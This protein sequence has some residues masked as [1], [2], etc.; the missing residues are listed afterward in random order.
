MLTK[1][2]LLLFIFSNLI[3]NYDLIH[4]TSFEKASSYKVFFDVEPNLLKSTFKPKSEAVWSLDLTSKLNIDLKYITALKRF[5]INK[6]FYL[7]QA[8]HIIQCVWII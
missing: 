1:L 6:S 8:I 7:Y 3:T 5:F 2:L 4:Q